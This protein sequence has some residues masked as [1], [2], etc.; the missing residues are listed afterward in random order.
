MN[1]SVKCILC[2][3]TSGIDWHH[4]IAQAHGGVNSEQV[5]LCGGHHTLVHTLALKL[6]STNDEASLIP[7]IPKDV[8]VSSYPKLFTLVRRLVIGRKAWEA[9][10]KNN[11]AP[12]KGKVVVTLDDKRLHRVKALSNMLAKDGKPLSRERVL[13]LAVDRLYQSQHAKTKP[14]QQ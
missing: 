14:Q 9:A 13:Q 5:P 10:Q 8:P 11:Q 12:K 1:D 2:G 6:Y 3:N 7:L 4:T